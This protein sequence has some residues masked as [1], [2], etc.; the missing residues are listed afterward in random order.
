MFVFGYFYFE[1]FPWKGK[2]QLS[3]GKASI[4]SVFNSTILTRW[5]IKRAFRVIYIKVNARHLISNKT[6]YN[7]D[8]YKNWS[9]KKMQE[10][11][12]L[13]IPYSD[14]TPNTEKRINSYFEGC[15]NQ[16]CLLMRR[17]ILWNLINQKNCNDIHMI[18][19]YFFERQILSRKYTFPNCL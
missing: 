17:F 3:V 8:M 1:N 16:V 5:Y 18:E 9:R 6:V 13:L 11:G 7:S 19:T 12:V 10:Y 2:N 14:V 15:I 4:H